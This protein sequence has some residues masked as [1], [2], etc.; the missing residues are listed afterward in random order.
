MG[1]LGLSSPDNLS[2]GS[3]LDFSRLLSG[4]LEEEQAND[5][6]PNPPHPCD[7][8]NIKAQK[9]SMV[10]HQVHDGV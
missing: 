6:E 2:N 7:L 10:I 4:R 9:R 5:F 3:F 8:N 1:F